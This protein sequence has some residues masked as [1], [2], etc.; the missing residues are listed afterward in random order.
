LTGNYEERDAVVLGGG[1]FGLFAARTLLSK[2]SSVT[3]LERDPKI[4]SRASSI[5]QARVHL[6]YHYPRSLGTALYSAQFFNRFV[7]DYA[8]CINRSFDKIYAISSRNSY[9]SAAQFE[10][11]CRMLNIP[12]E[13]VSPHLYFSRGS[14]E[15]CYL[16]KEYTFDAKL[17]ANAVGGKVLDDPRFE[18]SLNNFCVRVESSGSHYLLTC[19]DGRKIK[20]PLVVNATYASV[21]QVLELFDQECL[22][23]KYEI[24]ELA[25]GGVS[26]S[27]QNVGI[28]VMDGPFFSLIP[29]GLTGLHSLT[30]VEYTPHESSAKSLPTFSCQSETNGCSPKILKNCDTCSSRPKTSSHFMYQLAKRY[31]SSSFEFKHERSHFAVKAM[32]RTSEVDDARPTYVLVSGNGPKLVSVLSGKINTIYELERALS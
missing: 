12:V 32:L 19:A 4:F 5:N 2:K 18:L 10:S 13:P 21:N 23:M 31:L 3:L 16:T 17:L 7:E 9:T 14:V 8:E 30:G 22:P 24:T 20:T 26:E 28:T 1:I 15:G 29:H 6:G 27:F 25:L 11:F